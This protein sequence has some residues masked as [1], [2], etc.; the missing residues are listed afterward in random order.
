MRTGGRRRCVAS[1]LRRRIGDLLTKH[2][3][4]RPFLGDP[5]EFP[6]CHTNAHSIPPTWVFIEE[7]QSDAD[8]RIKGTTD[9]QHTR[10]LDTRQVDTAI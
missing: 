10:F 8:F 7:R 9:D 4:F 2:S 3:P 1:L 5:H 6:L